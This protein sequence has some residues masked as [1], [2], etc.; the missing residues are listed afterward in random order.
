LWHAD[1]S[2]H[3]AF[4]GFIQTLDSLFIDVAL[5]QEP[6]TPASAT[7]PSSCG[8]HYVG[9]DGTAGRDAGF[10]VRS[11]IE[12]NAIP[13]VPDRPNLLWRCMPRGPNLPNIVLASFWAPHVGCPEPERLAFWTLLSTTLATVR[14]LFPHAMFFVAGD[15]N[16]WI[17]E[18]VPIRGARAAD[19][20]SRAI[21]DSIIA[22]H[23][24]EIA[25]PINQATHRAGAA[26][27]I[28]LASPGL[29][30]GEVQVHNGTG[31]ACTNRNSCC[32]ALGSDHF[33]LT[34]SVARTAQPCDAS[35]LS[36]ACG[37]ARLACTHF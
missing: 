9:L 2:L 11:S 14:Q 12:L 18:L 27:D 37:C 36:F 23:G 5:I 22:D 19:R 15:S 21:L 30:A 1:G 10:L 16:L 35:P 7:L 33:L 17:P 24:L 3:D 29:I 25:N 34:A 32:P 4:P 13:Q 6:R 26:L 20:S 8:F 28:I 31:C